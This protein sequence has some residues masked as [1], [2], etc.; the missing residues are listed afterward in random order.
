ML[1]SILAAIAVS[2]ILAGLTLWTFS[3]RRRLAAL[4]ENSGNAL[5]Q[6]G[7]QLSARFD[8]LMALLELAKGYA[9]DMAGNFSQSI[10]AK[11]SPIT[12]KSSPED[13]IRQELVIAYALVCI[14][15]I[16]EKYPAFTA[17]PAYTKAM[18]AVQTFEGMVRT[19][20]L[21]YNDSVTKLNRE[22]RLFP[23]SMV[24]LICGQPQREYLEEWAAHKS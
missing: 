1:P 9:A 2:V 24:A 7:V 5:C 16:T 4:D 10:T 11:R 14:G 22:I 17:D 23:V 3:A 13:V 6:L 15:A 12:A 21:L 20:R 8:A 19:S 18:D